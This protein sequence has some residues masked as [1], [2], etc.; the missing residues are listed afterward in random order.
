M[1]NLN[2][3]R[4]VAEF[5][6]NIDD[7]IGRL[8][9]TKAPLLLTVDGRAELVVQDAASYQEIVDRLERAETVAALQRGIADVAEGRIMPLQEAVERIRQ[10]HGL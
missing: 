2:E 1:I 9:E 10:G 5:Q 7:Y 6:R 3:I 4:T 8:K